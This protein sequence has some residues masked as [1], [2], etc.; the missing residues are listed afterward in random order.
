MADDGIERHRFDYKWRSRFPDAERV[1]AGEGF[2]VYAAESDTAWWLISDEGT[3]ADFLDDDDLDGLVTVRRF[4]D[5]Q[6]WLQTVAEVSGRR[7]QVEAEAMLR[8][9]VPRVARLLEERAAEKELGWVNE[10]DHLQKWTVEELRRSVERDWP[11]GNVQTSVKLDHQNHW[12]RVGDVDIA[13]Q[14]KTGPP[15]FVELKSGRKADAFGACAW[16]LAK[17]ALSLRMG[18][19][20]ATYLLAATTT[21]LW[22]RPIRGGE[23]FASM[24][25]TTTAL[26]S[27]YEDWWRHWEKRGD[28][29]PR[30]LTLRGRT[31]PVAAATFVVAGLSWELRLSRVSVDAEGW[32]PWEPFFP[33]GPEGDGR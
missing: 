31:E 15:V 29:L 21:A 7:T 18:T 24:G 30:E 22:Q 20:A 26:R 32:Y 23:F 13:L 5:K 17:N 28:P 4:D 25:W 2:Q 8:A 16:D 1:A 19:A 33:D 3:L 27:D 14:G 6:A 9:A 10:R 12:P 11:G